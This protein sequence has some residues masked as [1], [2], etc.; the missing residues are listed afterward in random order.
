[1]PTLRLHIETETNGAWTAIPD[2]P[3]TVTIDGPVNPV[4][5][6]SRA[7]VA[8]RFW[9]DHTGHPGNVTATLTTPLDG[10]RG[11]GYAITPDLTPG[12][13]AA[14]AAAY[15]DG[16]ALTNR[17]DLDWTRRVRRLAGLGLLALDATVNVGGRWQTRYALTGPHKVEF[18]VQVRV[19]A[20]WRQVS[21]GRRRVADASQETLDVVADALAARAA[22]AWQRREV[23]AT[24]CLTTDGGHMESVGRAGRTLT[25]A[26]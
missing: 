7:I 9:R 5:L 26:Q 10:P 25:V 24:V 18:A 17:G 1:M 22:A 2:A 23:R 16:C 14:L 6:T 19:G 12:D 20:G 15:G 11:V 3:I 4:T 21:A 8:A 13:R